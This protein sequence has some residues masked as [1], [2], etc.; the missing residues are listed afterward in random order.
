MQSPPQPRDH[1]AVKTLKDFFHVS[2]KSRQLKKIRQA[3]RLIIKPMTT[4]YRTFSLKDFHQNIVSR[5][6]MSE[7]GFP[8][9]LVT[10]IKT[11]L[12]SYGVSEKIIGKFLDFALKKMLFMGANENWDSKY[13][14]ILKEHFFQENYFSSI[15]GKILNL[16]QTSK[17]H[18]KRRG[19]LINGPDGCGKTASIESFCA[20][21]GFQ[22]KKI[23]FASFSRI[24][25][26]ISV[27]K[28]SANVTDIRLDITSG[29]PIISTTMKPTPVRNDRLKS[30]DLV[31]EENNRDVAENSRSNNPG[32]LYSVFSKQKAS[33]YSTPKQLNNT[34]QRENSVNSSAYNSSNPKKIPFTP[35][36]QR[37]SSFF[38]RPQN[39]EHIRRKKKLFVFL[40]SEYLYSEYYFNQKSLLELQLS[41]LI[42]FCD[43]ANLTYVFAHAKKFNAI[44]GKANSD[45]ETIEF[46]MAY[47]RQMEIFIYIICFLELNFK[48]LFQNRLTIYTNKQGMPS[49]V[50]YDSIYEANCRTAKI[51]LAHH[52]AWDSLGTK[53]LWP[54]LKLVQGTIVHLSHNYKSALNKLQVMLPMIVSPISSK[55][56]ESK[57]SENGKWARRNL[58]S[59]IIGSDTR[60]KSSD[61]AE[62]SS[63]FR[64]EYSADFVQFVS[65]IELMD[66]RSDLDDLASLD[67]YYNL[68]INLDALESCHRLRPEKIPE[69]DA[70]YLQTI[71]KMLQDLTEFN[72]LRKVDFKKRQEP[73]QRV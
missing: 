40:N 10:K 64:H 49:E 18:K 66:I 7:V 63:L 65:D 56:E 42:N 16:V 62:I 3:E 71:A 26:I 72:F 70:S 68:Q 47:F 60:P 32:D 11:E 2:E 24:R 61:T 54:D 23:D 8:L 38:N 12:H 20:S 6:I 1:K 52:V 28:E 34:T 9:A 67:S 29:D 36:S 13:R 44:F 50:S 15:E 37:L 46:K 5:E 31:K 58:G 73:T 39:D 17:R 35:K 19:I 48:S 27:L 22:I 53:L 45:F 4:E 59:N 30:L 55:N 43:R 41:D 21:H 69:N 51:L 57:C 33:A 25:D 14:P